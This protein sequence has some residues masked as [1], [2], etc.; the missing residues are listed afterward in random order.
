MVRRYSYEKYFDKLDGK[1]KFL[2]QEVV[3]RTLRA[4]LS[5]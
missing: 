2:Q 1:A 4:E 3:S 5:L